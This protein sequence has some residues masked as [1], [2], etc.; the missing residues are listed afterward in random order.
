MSETPFLAS[1][2]QAATKRHDIEAIR[3]AIAEHGF[4]ESFDEWRISTVTEK[5]I[6]PLKRA[7][8]DWFKDQ[9]WF[10][11]KVA[12]DHEFVCH[13]PTLERAVEF[14]GT[15]EE[16]IVDMFY[17]LGWPGWAERHKLYQ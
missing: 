6:E 14:L 4:W 7:G 2:S 17:T 15:Y 5:R 10:R 3:R 16:L 11:V 12:C 13:S 8:P 9:T 1:L